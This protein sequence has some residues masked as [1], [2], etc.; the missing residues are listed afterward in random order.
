[1]KLSEIDMIS[2]KKV[3]LNKECE[4]FERKS[5][6]F[7]VN[8]SHVDSL[9]HVALKKVKWLA[10]NKILALEKVTIATYKEIE[11]ENELSVL[12][13]YVLFR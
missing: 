10:I 6:D 1:M 2:G 5:S 12:L 3:I 4:Y 9:K 7:D 13:I 11:F 8:Y